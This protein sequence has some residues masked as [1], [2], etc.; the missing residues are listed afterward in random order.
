M[1]EQAFTPAI[2]RFAPTRFYDPVVTLTRWIAG[3][4]A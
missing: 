1:S 2:G 4:V 3:V